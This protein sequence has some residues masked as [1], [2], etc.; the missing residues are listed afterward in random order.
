MSRC[1][2]TTQA[3]RQSRC[4]RSRRPRRQGAGDGVPRRL[5]CHQGD[6][7]FKGVPGLAARGISC[8][9]L[10]GPG[11]RRIRPL[12]QSLSAPRNR[13]Y[14]APATNILRPP[15]VRCQTH[16]R[17]GDQPRWLLRAARRLDRAALRLL[18]RVGRAVGLPE[19]LAT[20]ASLARARRHAVAVGG[21]G[22]HRC[23]SSTST[24]R[25]R[26]EAPGPSSSTAWCKK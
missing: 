1:P 24:S 2:M 16:R 5:R 3:C 11:Q 8:L 23:G 10:D 4:T 25:K 21:S 17:H 13:A 22:A 19:D 7:N 20:T 14:A 6:P 26:P 15:R 9:I 18:P 12:P